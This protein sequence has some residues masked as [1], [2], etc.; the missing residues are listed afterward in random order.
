MKISILI[1]I[2]LSMLMVG[3]GGSGGK[4]SKPASSSVSSTLSSAPASSAP[5]SSAQ[6][7]SVAA[8]VLK[9]V[10]LDAAVSNIGYRTSTQQGLTNANG[11]FNY[12]AGELITFF[13]GNLELPSVVAGDIITPLDIAN[14]QSL[15]DNQL[16]NILRLLQSL[17]A[18]GNASNGIEITA[19]AIAA[20][21]ALD[22]TLAPDLF[23]QLPAVQALLQATNKELISTE[24]A[25][26][27]F[28]TTLELINGPSSSSASSVADSSSSTSSNDVIVVPGSSTSSIDVGTSSSAN[29]STSTSSTHSSDDVVVIGSSSSVSSETPV[30]TN[31]HWNLY[32]A[33]YHPAATGAVTLADG[34][35]AAFNLGNTADHF[36]AVDG[37][38]ILDTSAAGTLTSGA[39]IANVVNA[40]NVYPKYFTLIAGI[41]GNSDN[42]RVLEL[43][44]AMADA[45]ATGS[46]L[47]T[48]LRNDGTNKGVQL[49]SANNGSSVNSYGVTDMDKF[50][51]YQIAITLTSSTKG[52][53]QVYRNGV[54]ML[55]LSLTNVTMRA[56]A[57]DA[58]ENFLRFG[59]VSGS[60]TYKSSIDWLVWTNEA[61]LTPAQAAESLPVDADLGCVYGY[62]EA[63]DTTTCFNPPASGSSSSSGSGEGSSSSSSFPT[64]DIRPAK[65]EGFAAHAGVTGGAGGPV[66]TVSTGTELNAALCGVRNGNRAAPV[67]I[68]VNGTINHA[69]T[70]SQGCDTQNDVIEIKNT[71]NISIIGVGT[72]A[73]FDEIGIHVRDASNII[74]QNL[75]IRNVK[76]SGSPT[77]NGG[78]AI[79]LETRV[80]RVW[81]DHNWLEASGGEKAG[82]D[83]LLDMKA[84]VTNVTVSYNLFNDSSR[85]GLI[86]SSDSDNKNTNITFHHNWYKNIE[87]RTPLIRHALVHV[88]N[89]YWSNPTQNYMFHGINS[90]MNAK[91]LVES[92]YFHNTNNPLIASDDSKEPGCWQTNNDN[93][94]T[95]SIYYSRT[96]G[97]GALV[98]PPV[99]DGQLQST[100]VVTVPYIVTMDAANDVPSIVMSNAGV[101]KIGN[102]GS[103][104]STGSSV[105]VS[106]STSSSA[107][108]VNPGSESSSVASSVDSSVATSSS[109]STSSSPAVVIVNTPLPFVEDFNNVVDASGF[110]STAYKALAT[111]EV[112]FYHSLSGTPIFANGE[113]NFGNARFTLGN[114]T[115]ATATTSSDTATTGELD[116]SQAYRISF[117]VKAA[118]GAGNVQVL[119]N[120]NTTGQGNS[121]HGNASRIYSVAAN[122]MTVGQRV[123][124]NAT[125]GSATSFVTLRAESTAQVTIDDLWVGYQNDLT[126]EPAANICVAPTPTAPAAPQ[127]TAGDAQLSVSWSAVS[128]AT[129]YEVVYNTV[130]SATGATTYA[131]NPVSGTSAVITG[132]TND[133][134]YFVF[135]RAVNASGNSEYSTSVSG[136]PEA[137]SEEPE[138]PSSNILLLEDFTGA[139][140]STFFT[141][142]YKSLPN[143]STLPLYL[144]ISN[145]ANAQFSNDQL[146]IV[147][148]TILTIGAT[149]SAA[150]TSSAQPAGTF[151]LSKPYKISFDVIANGTGSGKIQIQIDN[152][153]SGSGTSI[154]GASS[155]VY[156][157]AAASIVAGTVE[158]VD[159]TKTGNVPVGTANSHISI[160]SE[161][162]TK[163]VVIDNFKV[164]YIPQ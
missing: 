139:S 159:P 125:A 112:P 140:S 91:A 128:G 15:T 80:D 66:I 127:V 86:G 45:G 48:I 20:G 133:T 89:N 49:E 14:T 22:F 118:Q 113:M 50:A 33:L 108:S 39:S 5:S 68:M 121:I 31:V 51:I 79:G 36:T 150:T 151:D 10:F 32:N 55:N 87:Q 163:M 116:L 111:K 2:A 161:G 114:T 60:A 132:L 102:A 63:N 144:G 158:I 93:T 129:S 28:Q 141:A 126:T 142:S 69:N 27:H 26:A 130:D 131:N 56:T 123:V 153:T 35:A 24:Q 95:P 74:L 44:V 135:V 99:V 164:E 96:V 98:V 73:L 46:R 43:E 134:T 152:N 101:G 34:S 47:K 18:D 147:G 77:S 42:L 19:A 13:I 162:G 124:I 65:M 115:P 9:G 52:N 90:R 145:A 155:R 81:I 109:V 149:S 59:E 105:G 67:T 104:S 146:R 11:E 53:V 117:C 83:S 148:N 64:A 40:S 154:H 57:T 61:A 119:V 138:E 7:S 37:S 17:D 70:T 38:V 160:R 84:G 62:G 4:S 58:G 100:C 156:D 25:I 110:F 85:A 76:K 106:S 122:A 29:T 71:S 94:V 12:Q 6:A 30:N 23:A 75:H 103:S 78:D 3:C 120:N 157:V 143:N 136:K 72:N 97:N 88:Y 8:V 54:A 92:N 1:T 41:T 16:V 107:A 137:A 21:T 82:Y